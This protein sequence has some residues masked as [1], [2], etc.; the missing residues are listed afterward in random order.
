MSRECNMIMVSAP[1]WATPREQLTIRGLKCGYCH[2]N[3]YFWGMDETGEGV[4]RGCPICHGSGKVDAEITIDY[5]PIKQQE[6]E[7][8]Y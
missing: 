8:D 6:D 3:G 2:G 7:K 1:T 4:K 5:K